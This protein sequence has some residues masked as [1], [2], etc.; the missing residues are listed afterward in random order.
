[1]KMRTSGFTKED[2]E[3]EKQLAEQEHNKITAEEKAKQELERI[4]EEKKQL[5]RKKLQEEKLEMLKLKQ[6]I[7]DDVEIVHEEKAVIEKPKGT[8]ALENFWYHYSMYIIIFVIFFAIAGYLIFNLVSK[9]TPDMNV[10]VLPDSGFSL[11]L[12][13]FE[14][15]VENFAVDKN[16]DGKVKVTA[17]HI[18]MELYGQNPTADVG[19]Q[20]KLMGEIKAGKTML[21][22]S[23]KKADEQLGPKGILMDIR[24][25]YPDNPNV[26]EYGFEL[27]GDKVK[28]ALD[29]TDMPDGIY[30]GIRNP[31]YING[32]SPEKA[33]KQYKESLKIL[34]KMIKDL[35]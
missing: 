7:V 8:K 4:I 9:V 31:K 10:L 33:Q 18:P 25:L 32:V 28:K 15:Y 27:E 6:G 14:N 24:D 3:Y 2:A 29:W 22:V 1:M 21:I 20:A 12:K 17:I 19:Y 5:H 16:K 23:N 13:K 34:D 26:T 35:S 11:K 30:I